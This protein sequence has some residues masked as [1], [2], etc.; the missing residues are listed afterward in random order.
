MS[1]VRQ[2]LMARSAPW[3]RGRDRWLMGLAIGLSAL[4]VVVLIIVMVRADGQAES[5]P[6][7]QDTLV[8]AQPD[9]EE[10]QF[11]RQD[12]IVADD[13]PT[14][15]PFGVGEDDEGP[16]PVTFTAETSGGTEPFEVHNGLVLLRVVHNGTGPFEVQLVPEGGQGIPVLVGNGSG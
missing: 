15:D 3:S 6:L 12:P 13:D 8:A 10:P 11:G 5:D 4:I 7:A 2:A 9:D 1:K 16:P 14:D